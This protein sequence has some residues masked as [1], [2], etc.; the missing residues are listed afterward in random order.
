MEKSLRHICLDGVLI[1]CHP[2]SA[3]LPSREQSG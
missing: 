2:R 1:P 3:G